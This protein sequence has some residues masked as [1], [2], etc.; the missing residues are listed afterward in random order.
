MKM[1]QLKE[2]VQ[3]VMQEAIQQESKASDEANAR[4]YSI[5]VL[6]GMEKTGN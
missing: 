1:Y 3:E 2:L 5:L 4:A 6:G